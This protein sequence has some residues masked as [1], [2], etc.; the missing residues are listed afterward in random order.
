MLPE[1]LRR[2]RSQRGASTIELALYTPI[3]FLIIFV[4]VQ[5]TLTWHGNQ[6]ASSAARVAAREARTGGGTPQALDAAEAAAV[7]YAEVVGNGQLVDIR[8]E[9]VRVGDNVRVTVSGRAN[10]IINNLSPRVSQTVEGPVE[11]F[12]PDT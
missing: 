12:V 10:E 8:V 1:R 11:Q 3:M 2:L 6:V 5:F 4:I 7:D 9:A